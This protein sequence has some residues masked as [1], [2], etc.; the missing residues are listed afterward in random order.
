MVPWAMTGILVRYGDKLT[1]KID[2]SV[3]HYMRDH[4]YDLRAYLQSNWATL[5]PQ[6]IGKLHVVC[7]DMDDYYLNLSVYLFQ[8]FLEN[9]TNPYYAGSFDFGRPMKGHGWQPMTMAELIRSMARDISSHAP[10]G[11]DSTLWQY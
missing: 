4:G 7:G 2:H 8:D 9:T 3:A 6:L 10:H 5:G 11:E 1:G